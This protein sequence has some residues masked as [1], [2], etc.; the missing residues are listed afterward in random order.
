VIILL[1]GVAAIALGF[2]GWSFGAAERRSA[3]AMGMITLLVTVVLFVIVDLNRP[4]RGLIRV[5]DESI[6]RL[7]QSIESAQP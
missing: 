6:L 5:G 7:Q 2:I 1:V 3:V 4:H